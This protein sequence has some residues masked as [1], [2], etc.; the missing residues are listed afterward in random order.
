MFLLYHVLDQ[1]RPCLCNHHYNTILIHQSA[2]AQWTE[3]QTFYFHVF[4][5]YFYLLSQLFITTHFDK[6]FCERSQGV[7]LFVFLSEFLSL[8]LYLRFCHLYSPNS[9]TD[10]D[11]N[12]NQLSDKIFTDA[13]FRSF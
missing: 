12:F 4:S 7:R 9:D 8:C 3:H 13:C 11:N 2:N 1:S 6:I 5:P 10:F